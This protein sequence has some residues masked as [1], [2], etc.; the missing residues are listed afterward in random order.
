MNKSRKILIDAYHLNIGGGAI[1]LDELLITL[2]SE[3]LD[4]RVILDQRNYLQQKKLERGK[5][6]ICNNIIERHIL[7]WKYR[8]E[9]SSVLYLNGIPP[10]MNF[11]KATTYCYFQNVNIF[12]NRI[13]R[14][15]FFRT[16][17]NIDYWVV[18]TLITEKLLKD[19]LGSINVYCLPFFRSIRSTTELKRSN[20]ALF[21]Y[22]TS[23]FDHKNN[24]VIIR[25]FSKNLRLK[26]NKEL[27]L[28]ITLDN[29]INN[30]NIK[31]TGTLPHTDLVALMEK[32]DV[33]LN[34][35]L[36]ESFGLYLIEAAMLKKPIIS[37]DL[38][39]VHE[40]INPTI[41]FK[42]EEDLMLKISE[43]KLETLKPAT[44]KI[45]DKRKELL[46]LLYD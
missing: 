45:R 36:N 11:T 23:N 12:N 4:F 16:K 41:T 37:I 27:F 44:M 30:D 35:S 42:S 32:C 18:Q 6:F 25:V 10:F 22:P 39:Y 13:K 28:F 15:Y 43:L 24:D 33:I 38:P 8:D 31:F 5:Y 19:H 9:G 17:K 7:L 20:K 46:N 21:L 2:I 3:N 40:I 29:P 26:N 14:W 34:S 1:L